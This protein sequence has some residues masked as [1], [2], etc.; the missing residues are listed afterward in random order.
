MYALA[1]TREVVY[2]E[3]GRNPFLHHR[4]TDDNSLEIIQVLSDGGNVL[5]K[6]RTYPLTKG[7]VLFIDAADIHAINPLDESEYCRNKW[8]LE[9]DKTILAFKA[10][11]AENLLELFSST[12]IFVPFS[13][14]QAEKVD[15][16]FR[17]AS[18][19][20]D[21]QN[22]KTFS[23]LLRLLLLAMEEK[24]TV[25]EGCDERV[26]FV[27]HYLHT[28]FADVISID[29]L[30]QDAHLNKFYLCHLF[31]AQ[32]GM[33][34]MQYL[35]ETRLAVARKML[36]ETKRSITQI[37]QDCGFG[38]AS[39]FCTFFKAREGISPREYRLQDQADN[40]T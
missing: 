6:D 39:H 5:I 25:A 23:T 29:K 15:H 7:T 33:T 3:V 16:L 12:S 38:S 31:H 18:R 14:E 13:E 10:I 40:K 8:I 11:E 19:S 26:H 36:I 21:S 9:K 22:G 24:E 27:L 1:L 37:A 17:S 34:V 20:F 4:H 2:Q 30:A 35:K 28:H 32:T